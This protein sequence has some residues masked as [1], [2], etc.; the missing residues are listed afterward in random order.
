MAH[1]TDQQ[2]IR[3]IRNSD[4]L[5]FEELHRRYWH[6]LHAIAYRR[7]G[8]AEETKDLLQELFLELWEIREDLYFDNAVESWLRNR[9]WFKVARYFRD[10]GSSQRHRQHF[11]AFLQSEPGYAVVTNGTE[12]REEEAFYQEILTTLNQ[13]I[14]D[15][16]SRMKEVFLLSRSGNFTVREIA[17]KLDIS[18]Q[19]VKTQLERAMARLRKAAKAHHPTTMEMLFILWLINC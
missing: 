1:W 13:T 5:A 11:L 15:M 17:E 16:P 7:I 12:L 10:K 6:I 9:L 18:P 4:A 3:A 8:D 2:L 19:T 14:Q